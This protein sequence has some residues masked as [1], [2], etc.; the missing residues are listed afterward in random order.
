VEVG[1]G[2]WMVSKI[3]YGSSFIGSGTTPDSS[4]NDYYDGD[5]NWIQSVD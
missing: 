4:N 1:V 2:G 3:T 5:L